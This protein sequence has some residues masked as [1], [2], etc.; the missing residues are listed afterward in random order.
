MENNCLQPYNVFRLTIDY[1]YRRREGGKMDLALLCRAAESVNAYSKSGV[2]VDGRL[3]YRLRNF[4]RIETGPFFFCLPRVS[5]TIR[6][7]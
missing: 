7:K 6:N 1:I 5:R 4:K 2:C 3:W